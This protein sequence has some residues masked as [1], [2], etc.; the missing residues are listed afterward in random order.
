M[1][2]LLLVRHGQASFLSDEYDRLS[3]L[4]ERQSRL[5]ANDWADRGLVFDHVYVGPRRRHQQTHD[6]VASVYRERRLPWPDPVAL[7]AL[8]EYQAIQLMKR[9]LPSLTQQDPAIREW[10]AAFQQGGG[11]AK[12]EFD[13]VFGKVA[14]MWVRGELD[15][16][17]IESWPEFRARVEAGIEKMTRVV[18]NGKTIAAFTSAGAIA[19]AAGFALG[20]GNEKTLELSWVV[21]N[22]AYTEFLFSDGRFSLSRFNAIP[23]ITDPGLV[24]RH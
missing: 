4:G 11:A 14:R 24:T 20:L 23:H 9:S 22:A 3:P 8:D 6:A 21:S 10:V 17:D 13:R 12:R 2:V 1:S 7:P 5:L 16:P 15:V 18:G 19:A